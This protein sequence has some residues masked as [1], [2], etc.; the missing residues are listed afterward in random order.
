MSRN[1]AGEYVGAVHARMTWQT[2]P[3]SPSIA[4]WYPDSVRILTV[5][6]PDT[7]GGAALLAN[8]ISTS[9]GI[10]YSLSGGYCAASWARPGTTA[11]HASSSAAHAA[12]LQRFSAVARR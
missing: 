8:A 2:K 5:A 4:T 12:L 7:V 1:C 9:R 3:L 11:V 6:R 10:M